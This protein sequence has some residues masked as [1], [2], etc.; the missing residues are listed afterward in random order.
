MQIYL[1]IAADI[2][3]FRLCIPVKY[4]NGK[5][6]HPLHPPVFNLKTTKSKITYPKSRF[7]RL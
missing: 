7:C 1:N 6:Q 3:I 5:E 2:N 4:T